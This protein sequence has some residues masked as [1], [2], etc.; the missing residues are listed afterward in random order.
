MEETSSSE[1]LLTP[2]RLCNMTTHGKG[3]FKPEMAFCRAQQSKGIICGRACAIVSRS[4]V[5]LTFLHYAQRVS[6]PT[7][8]S[9]RGL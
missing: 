8:D 9:V 3:N 5:S 1:M 7:D 4:T 6:G 2:S